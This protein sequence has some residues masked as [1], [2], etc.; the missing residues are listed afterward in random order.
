MMKEKMDIMM[1]TM[2]GWVSTNLDKLVHRT[3]FLFIAQVTSFPFPVKFRILQLEAYDE[4][5]RFIL[6]STI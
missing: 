6:S 2:R 4:S 5:S 3:D 1:N